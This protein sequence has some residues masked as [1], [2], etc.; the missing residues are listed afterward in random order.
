MTDHF[1]PPDP[2]PEPP[3]V[4][5]CFDAYKRNDLMELFEKMPEDILAYGYFTTEVP[6]TAKLLANSTF[7]YEK[8]KRTL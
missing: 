5:I 4:A 8:T 3:H 1:L 7:K 2:V 6:D